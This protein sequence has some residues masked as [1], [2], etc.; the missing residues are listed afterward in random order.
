M[1]PFCAGAMLCECQFI[2]EQI[3]ACMFSSGGDLT[4]VSMVQSG[5][6]LNHLHLCIWLKTHCFVCVC[7]V[8]STT[9]LVCSKPKMVEAS[10]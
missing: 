10:R 1:N 7:V 9:S 4:S 8:Q 6:T 3:I 5:H 2:L